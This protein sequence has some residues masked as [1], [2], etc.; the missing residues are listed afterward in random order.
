MPN[1]YFGDHLDPEFIPKLIPRGPNGD[2][3]G[4][5]LDYGSNWTKFCLSGP[6]WKIIRLRCLFL[7]WGWFRPWIHPQIDPQGTKW[8]WIGNIPYLWIKLD[9]ISFEWTFLANNK[10]KMPNLYFGKDL[11]PEFIPKLIPRWPA[12]DKPYLWAKLGQIL[13][14]WTF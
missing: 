4:I 8:G 2:E 13:L 5:F 9:Q 10:I 14:D 7:F 3:L 11:D 12:G 6:F 1:L